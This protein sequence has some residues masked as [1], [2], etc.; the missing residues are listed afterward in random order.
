MD[1]MLCYFHVALRG[2]AR[3]PSFNCTDIDIVLV[4]TVQ[5]R[6]L[7]VLTDQMCTWLCEP[8][9]VEGA[10]T[11]QLIEYRLVVVFRMRRARGTCVAGS[12]I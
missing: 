12:V 8:R 7:P 2:E 5:G 3:F 4:C 10:V 9:V 11:P 1:T 6:R